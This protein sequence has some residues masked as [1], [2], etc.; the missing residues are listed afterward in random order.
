MD[1]QWKKLVTKSFSLNGFSM[2]GDAMKHIINIINKENKKNQVQQFIDD[3][4]KNI[5]KNQLKDNLID[6]S[7]IEKA[8][9]NIKSEND[10]GEIEK[11]AL[12]V[13]GAFDV[14]LFS[15]DSNHKQFIK[16]EEYDRSLHSDAIS[17]SLLYK[18][19]YE[20]VYQRLER[21]KLFL[22]PS[23]PSQLFKRDFNSLT[24][25]SSLLGNQGKKIVL[26]T[27][28]QIT[29]D[30][31]Y[32]EDLNTNVPLDFSKAE[33]EL[34]LITEGS[35]VQ[36][37]GELV[38]KTFIADKILLP[39]VEERKE[40]LEYLQQTD[41]FGGLPSNKVLERLEKYE[42]EM[43]DN[44]IL[45][46][47]DVWLDSEL[48]LEKLDYV[49]ESYNEDPPF[50]IVLMGNFTEH[51][52]SNGSQYNLK[53]YF[54]NLASIITKH[55]NFSNTRFIFVPGPT[56]PIGSL[57]NI[58]P[59][60]SIPNAFV[61]DFK[62]K[63]PNSI[64]TTNPCRIRYCTQEIIVF[65]DDLVN[66]MRRHCIIEPSDEWDISQHLIASICSNGHLCN[67]SIEDR[68]IYWNYDH[69]LSVYPLPNVLVLG[70]KADQYEHNSHEMI[71]INPSSFS[72][73]FSFSH[74]IPATKK[75]IFCSAKISGG[76]NEGNDQDH[77]K[78]T[79]NVD[80]SLSTTTKD[81][82]S[83]ADIEDEI[84]SAPNFTKNVGGQDGA[85]KSK[86]TKKATK[87][88]NDCDHS[89][90]DS[91]DKQQELNQ[92]DESGEFDFESDTEQQEQEEKQIKPDE[93]ER[94]QQMKTNKRVDIFDQ[95]DCHA[96]AD[97]ED[98]QFFSS[99]SDDES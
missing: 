32:L 41:M 53:S 16:C 73:D 1:L 64:F 20:R 15:F 66:R 10:K 4:L 86:A 48:V 99:S 9:H 28:S 59:K 69:A 95:E 87:E 17:K 40:S 22:Q 60:S 2:K 31:Y 45:F 14:P 5:D 25:L 47:C 58:L 67:L 13:I 49:L 83:D 91:D 33:F 93:F 80:D 72:T 12:T 82:L 96:I 44:A 79:M 61:K 62:A 37:Y 74:Y 36:V 97:E 24:P 85:Q 29:E 42:K 18:R 50:A 21:H 23:I 35:I 65:R 6:L 27:I 92:M 81:N 98:F 94:V 88:T 54:D 26:G 56:D 43:E 8:I 11:D 51:P 39:P 46:L 19:R 77:S 7:I 71:C 89:D 90:I 63:V 75:S 76:N 3:I 38:G 55:S 34:G 57:I 52:L 78:N 30:S 70:D 68:P 84:F